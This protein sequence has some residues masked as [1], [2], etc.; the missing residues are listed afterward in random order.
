[1]SR[2]ALVLLVC[3]CDFRDGAERLIPSKSLRNAVIRAFPGLFCVLRMCAPRRA[4]AV[5]RPRGR[6]KSADRRRRI[7]ISRLLIIRASVPRRKSPFPAYFKGFPAVSPLI[8]P[9]PAF[10]KY[11]VSP[12]FPKQVSAGVG[13]CCRAAAIGRAMEWPVSLARESFPPPFA[14]A[15]ITKP[16]QPIG[17]EGFVLCNQITSCTVPYTF[18][19]D[20]PDSSVR[21]RCRRRF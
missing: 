8:P 5:V 19:S 13:P 4:A 9:Y 10:L 18:W 12:H 20:N 1:M 7:L 14:T 3:C 2:E 16:S 21:R 17:R 15:Y 11:P 6:E